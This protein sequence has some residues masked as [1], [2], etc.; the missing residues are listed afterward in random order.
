MDTPQRDR[1]TPSEAILKRV[2][3]IGVAS[4]GLVLTSWLIALAFLLATLDTGRFGFFSQ[5]RI[6]RYGRPFKLLKIRTMRS[7]ALPDTTVTT[8][9]DERITPFGGWLRKYKIDELPQLFNVLVGQMSLVGPRPDVPGFADRLTGDDR[10]ILNV[11]PGITGPATLEYR[12]EE[13]VLSRQSDP[14]EY[15]AQVI[16]PEKV[17]LNKEYIQ[18]YSFLGD[19]RCIWRT[20]VDRAARTEDS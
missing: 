5:T 12:N 1:L 11:R 15:N 19:V 20:I 3:D 6:G 17:K 9:T 13:Y 8:A 10:I 18:T 4:I 2:L 7:A 16:F 14:E